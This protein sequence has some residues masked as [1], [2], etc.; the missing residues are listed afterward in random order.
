M[1]TIIGIAGV[2]TSGK[3]TVATMIQQFVPAF[4]VALADKLKNTGAEVFGLNRIDFD[5]QDI[6]EVPFEF[7]KILTEEKIRDIVKSF[8]INNIDDTEFKSIFGGL[9]DMPL[10]SPRH[11][12]QI[13]GTEILRV[14]G[15]P[16]IHCDNVP[17]TRD[18][19]VISD[20]RFPNEFNYFNNLDSNKFKFIPL[21][22][23]RDIAESVVDLKTSHASEISVFIFRDKCIRVD[24]NVSMGQLKR[25]VK[26]ILDK[27]FFS[28]G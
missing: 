24:N 8:N 14:A 17:L 18:V 1:Q 21:Y 16:D 11:I 13:I 19:I 2:K 10:D 23:A 6:K 22:V 3:S 5:S 27:E 20:L 9:I 7:P 4:E 26:D 28:E 15:G 12:A 25:N